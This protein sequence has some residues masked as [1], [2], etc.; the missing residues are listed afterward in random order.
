MKLTLNNLPN[1]GPLIFTAFY[2]KLIKKTKN[3]HKQ[4]KNKN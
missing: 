3:P 1:T 2:I 4:L